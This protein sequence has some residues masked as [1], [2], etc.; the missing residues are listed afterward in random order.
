MRARTLGTTTCTTTRS[1][2]KCWTYL[3]CANHPGKRETVGFSDGMSLHLER[4][5]LL[6]AQG[7]LPVHLLQLSLHLLHPPAHDRSP[8]RSFR[9]SASHTGD[10]TSC[11]VLGIFSGCRSFLDC[12]Q[13]EHACKSQHVIADCTS[14]GASR[15]HC[16]RTSTSR[17]QSH[18]CHLSRGFQT[19]L[20]CAPGSGGNLRVALRL[21]L[22]EVQELPFRQTA[23]AAAATCATRGASGGAAVEQAL[24]ALE[25]VAAG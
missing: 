13:E 17:A 25:A 9:Q 1:F 4:R 21:L 12:P 18:R 14:N 5:L 8:Q 3:K 6:D 10:L 20:H 16:H 22:D 11:S 15:G 24:Q 19:S 23:A 2:S 7:Q